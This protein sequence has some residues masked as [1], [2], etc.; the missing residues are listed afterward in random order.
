MSWNLQ[1]YAA[2]KQL[3]I[4]RSRYASSPTPYAA[5]L[6]C[7][8]AYPKAM[9]MFNQCICYVRTVLANSLRTRASALLKH[10]EYAVYGQ[11]CCCAVCRSTLLI[12]NLQS[13][14]FRSIVVQCFK[15]RLRWPA[16]FSFSG[17]TALV[18]ELP[19]VGRPSGF[20]VGLR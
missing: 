6:S 2:Y 11:G 9:S 15:G 19:G 3:A 13:Y 14:G 10:V 17:S 7:H 5:A 18:F 1:E 16:G 4:L 12:S 8:A 20:S